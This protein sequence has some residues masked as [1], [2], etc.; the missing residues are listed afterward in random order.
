MKRVKLKIVAQHKEL[1]PRVLLKKRLAKKNK[2]GTRQ[3]LSAAE[4]FHASMLLKATSVYQRSQSTELTRSS[5][6][7]HLAA[8]VEVERGCLLPILASMDPKLIRCCFFQ[9]NM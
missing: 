7:G 2:E 4:C 8:H 6:N 3:C 9:V 5:K 1:S